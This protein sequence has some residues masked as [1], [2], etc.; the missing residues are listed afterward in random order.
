MPAIHRESNIVTE[1]STFIFTICGTDDCTDDR[2]YFVTD[3]SA[4]DRTEQRADGLTDGRTLGHSNI[5]TFILSDELTL[6]VTHKPTVDDAI[7]HSID[8]S[9]DLSLC[10]TH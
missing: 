10:S 6:G 5:G 3:S 7:Y 2:T 8:S 1:H 9:H 4:N